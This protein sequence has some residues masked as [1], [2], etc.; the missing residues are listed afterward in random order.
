[1][2]HITVRDG[3]KK[4]LSVWANIGVFGLDLT[5]SFR[6]LYVQDH[7]DDCS[8]RSYVAFFKASNAIEKIHSVATGPAA[9]VVAPHEAPHSLEFYSGS[10]TRLAMQF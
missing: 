6:T 1:L 2:K 9:E 8:P 3:G 4:R 5:S 7:N 10:E